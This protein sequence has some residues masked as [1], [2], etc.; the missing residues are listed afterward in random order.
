MINTVK[1]SIIPFVGFQVEKITPEE[2]TKDLNEKEP[3]YSLLS[4]SMENNFPLLKNYKELRKDKTFQETR[5]YIGMKEYIGEKKYMQVC[6]KIA[7]K[8]GIKQDNIDRTQS[9]I[10]EIGN[11]IKDKKEFTYIP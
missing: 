4:P 10:N 1:L 9:V 11:V 6:E 3:H 2:K 5:K 7:G 8:M